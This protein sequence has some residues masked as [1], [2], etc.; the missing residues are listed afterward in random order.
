MIKITNIKVTGHTTPIVIVCPE[1]SNLNHYLVHPQSKFQAVRP[2]I[3]CGA[4]LEFTCEEI[5]DEV[6]QNQSNIK[7]AI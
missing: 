6:E 7:E 1:C 2:C 5:K 3:G 4:I